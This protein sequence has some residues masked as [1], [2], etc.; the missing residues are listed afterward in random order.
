MLDGITLLINDKKLEYKYEITDDFIIIKCKNYNCDMQLFYDENVFEYMFT[1]ELKSK[2]LSSGKYL[3]EFENYNHKN[4]NINFKVNYKF[5]VKI[6]FKYM[7]K[8][9][10]TKNLLHHI[11]IFKNSECGKI[12]FNEI[13]NL[14]KQITDKTLDNSSD[15]KIIYSQL[16]NILKSNDLYLKFFRKM[17]ETELMLILT[18]YIICWEAPKISQDKFDKLV[19]AAINYDVSLECV[20]RL[21]MTYDSK[22]YNYKILDDFFIQSRDVWYLGEYISGIIQIN[23]ESIVKKILKT[24]DKEFISNVV[25][26]DFIKNDLDEKY[27]L[28]LKNFI[29]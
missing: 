26:D 1:K 8:Q 2:Q 28:I 11:A 25:N 13:N 15:D 7:N 3:F 4:I 20:W 17:N 5:F 21:G 27:L 14:E 12:Y 24:K 6:I 16:Y 29:D 9:L 19:T 22:G 10:N 23:Q 18:D